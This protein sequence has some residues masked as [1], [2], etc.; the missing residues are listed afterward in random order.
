MHVQGYR[1]N[2]RIDTPLGLL[3]RNQADRFSLTLDAIKRVPKLQ[4]EG[5]K[6]PKDQK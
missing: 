6:W 2:G 5:S 3:M 4:A 1:E